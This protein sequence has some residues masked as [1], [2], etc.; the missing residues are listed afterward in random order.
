M[1]GIIFQYPLILLYCARC[2][3]TR[4]YIYTWSHSIGEDSADHNELNACLFNGEFGGAINPKKGVRGETN[5]IYVFGLP[6]L[7]DS[8][9][10]LLHVPLSLSQ[11][12]SIAI[13]L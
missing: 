4:I 2:I 9:D 1:I 5:Q 6:A 12:I 10:S 7:T 13:S 11:F 8:N 3:Y